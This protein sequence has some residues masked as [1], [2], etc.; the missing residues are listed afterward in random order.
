MA[1]EEIYYGGKEEL[2]M[3]QYEALTTLEDNVDYNI[4]DYPDKGIT[5]AQMTFA[6]TCKRL[7]ND[8]EIFTCNDDG[9]YV[10][11]HSYRLTVLNDAKSW[12]DVTPVSEVK[13]DDLTISHNT[14]NQLQAVGLTDGTN[15]DTFEE[16]NQSLTIERL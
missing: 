4:T 16:I 11:G 3:A 6:L 1:V 15:V 2:T 9:D 12:I 14:S 10:E 8:G 13:T 7:F 5:N